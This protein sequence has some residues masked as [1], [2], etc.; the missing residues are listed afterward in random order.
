MGYRARIAALLSLTT[1]S[2]YSVLLFQPPAQADPLPAPYDGKAH[3]DIVSVD[4]DVAAFDLAKV[5]LGH[6]DADADSSAA[7]DN[8]NA[9]SR[10][11]DVMVAGLPLAIEGAESHAPVSESDTFSTIPLAIPG[12]L[13]LGVLNGATAANYVSGTACAPGTPERVLSRSST[14]LISATVAEVPLGLGSLAVAQVGAS[15]TTATTKLVD[16]GTGASSMVS[17]TTS[18]IGDIRLL[19]NLVTVHVADPVVLSTKSD[20]ATGVAT[21]SDPTVTVTVAGQPA[22]TLNDIDGGTFT[23]NGLNVLGLATADVTISL[24]DFVGDT[25]PDATGA[26]SLDAV[27]T[28]NVNLSLLT[29]VELADVTLRVSPMSATATAPAG[30]VECGAL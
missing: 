17:E 8:T 27:V 21:Y 14:N 5:V 13:S 30:G 12:L 23:T 26:A 24:V 4:A 10:N 19:G 29:A 7:S 3:G 28:A 25:T 16:D 6:A 2:L 9:T 18:E 15:S 22:V 1:A 11:L 20:G